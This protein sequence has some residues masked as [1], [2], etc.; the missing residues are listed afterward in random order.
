M[1]RQW[2]LIL[3]LKPEQGTPPIVAGAALKPLGSRT[4]GSPARHCEYIARAN[5]R[6]SSSNTYMLRQERNFVELVAF[7][8]AKNVLAQVNAALHHVMN[9]LV[10]PANP[11]CARLGWN[12]IPDAASTCP[13]RTKSP[14]P[15]GP[16]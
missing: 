5:R 13:G 15:A 3:G 2:E 9:W 12:C 16:E 10:L 8:E 11:N 4:T 1:G 6:L 7:M 14:R